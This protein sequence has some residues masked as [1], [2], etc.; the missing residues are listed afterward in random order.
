MLATTHI[1]SRWS[2]AVLAV[3][4]TACFASAN[5]ASAQNVNTNIP[6]LVVTEDQDTGS[7]N[8]CNDVH[9]RVTG[10]GVHLEQKEIVEGRLG[11][12]D[13]RGENRLLADVHVQEQRSIRQP[14]R[15][16]VETAQSPL[17]RGKPGHDG[18]CKRKRR[19]RR[20]RRGNERSD[21]RAA[22]RRLHVASQA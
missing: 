12:F 21:D 5:P 15:D 22:D 10:L 3:V 19:V 16:A 9:K 1:A 6:V 20:E 13:L 14:R 17:R 7:I 4:A 8:H 2:S 18:G 11:A